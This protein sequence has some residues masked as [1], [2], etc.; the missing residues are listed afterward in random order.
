MITFIL[1]TLLSLLILMANL[2]LNSNFKNL[3]IIDYLYYLINFKLIN[4]KIYINLKF[5]SIFRF[6]IYLFLYFKLYFSFVIY[7]FLYKK[8]L[9]FLNLL[10]KIFI[11]LYVIK[12]LNENFI[13]SNNNNHN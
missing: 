13:I 3:I 8:Y 10:K 9:P 12:N 11:K 4:I 5:K 7:L 2:F 1:F 6:P